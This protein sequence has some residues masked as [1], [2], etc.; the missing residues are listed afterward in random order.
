ML[1][2]S[3]VMYRMLSY[4]VMCLVQ[5][6]ADMVKAVNVT[7]YAGGNVYVKCGYNSSLTRNETH[8]CEQLQS[9]NCFNFSNTRNQ[10]SGSDRFFVNDKNTGYVE[11]G[12][13]GL[14]TQDTGQYSCPMGTMAG[15][16]VGTMAGAS[17]TINL[18]VKKG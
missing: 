13:A 15:G 5:C 2:E 4:H 12:L 8:L 17:T 7:A 18:E 14:T 9:Q 10:S 3:V 16:P 11:V 1:K 6:Y